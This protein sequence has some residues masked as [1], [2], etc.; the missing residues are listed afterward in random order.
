MNYLLSGA[1]RERHMPGLLEA[2]HV[3]LVQ[4]GCLNDSGDLLV[5]SGPLHGHRIG[6]WLR[7]AV[8]HHADYHFVRLLVE[9]GNGLERSRDC[10][11]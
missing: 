6:G 9:E 8:L 2:D 7:N 4:S 11:F 10:K 3:H 1:K 5:Q